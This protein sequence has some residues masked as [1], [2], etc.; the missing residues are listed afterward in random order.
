MFEPWNGEAW[1]GVFA[2]GGLLGMSGLYTTPD[3]TSVCVVADGEGWLVKADDPPSY[4]HVACIPVLHVTPVPGSRL[5]VFGSH[6]E[7]IAY[8]SS[9]VVWQTER[10]AHSEFDITEVTS[11]EIVGVTP[12]VPGGEPTSFAVD[13]RTG[14]LTGG[15]FAED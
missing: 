13:L 14:G 2:G 6:T 8:G 7:L 3:P 11:S 5:L 10:L 15:P 4:E 12:R 1:V 9:G